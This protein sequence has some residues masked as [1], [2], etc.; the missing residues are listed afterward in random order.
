M[1]SMGRS[2][3]RRWTSLVHT[4]GSKSGH[5]MPLGC[6][7]RAVGNQ[8]GRSLRKVTDVTVAEDDV[9]RGRY[10]RIRVEI[11]LH[12]P[13]ERGRSLIIS[14]KSLWVS[15]KN[16]K[17]PVFCFRCGRIIHGPSGCP[18]INI[19]KQSHD[20]GS[21][22]WGIWLRADDPSK[23]AWL[24]EGQRSYRSPSPEMSDSGH[25]AELMGGMPETESQIP[26]GDLFSLTDRIGLQ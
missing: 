22:G 26:T 9:G 19:R 10:L 18:E 12:Q 17:L 20:G 11:N 15:F 21:E 7:N 8:I 23:R 4:F 5:D 1:I 25:N 24:K 3:L 16:E 14:G 13:L 2:L 6:M